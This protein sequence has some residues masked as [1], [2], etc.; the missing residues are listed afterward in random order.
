LHQNV[1]KQGLVYDYC[2]F[3][4]IFSQVGNWVCWRWS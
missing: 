4:V 1:I 3:S 2:S